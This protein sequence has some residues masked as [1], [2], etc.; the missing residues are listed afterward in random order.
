MDYRDMAPSPSYERDGVSLRT[1]YLLGPYAPR[2]GSVLLCGAV[3]CRQSCMLC[4]FSPFGA[5]L[6]GGLLWLPTPSGYKAMA[7]LVQANAANAIVAGQVT[8]GARWR[9]THGHPGCT[10]IST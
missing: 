6:G 3:L 10:H 9:L 8:L 7:S 2:W 1:S 4:F 5:L